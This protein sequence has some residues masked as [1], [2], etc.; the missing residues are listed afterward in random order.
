MPRT[1]SKTSGIDNFFS[2]TEEE[3]LDNAEKDKES[4]EKDKEGKDIEK[5]EEEKGKEAEKDK[6]EGEEEQEAKPSIL[7]ILATALGDE[8][9]EEFS[10]KENQTVDDLTEYVKNTRASHTTHFLNQVAEKYPDIY[11]LLE[12]ATKGGDYRKLY[13]QLTPIKEIADDDSAKKVLEEHYKAKGLSEKVIKTI[14]E[15]YEAEE[16]LI[17]EANKVNE[18]KL[19]EQEALAAKEVERVKQE[20]ERINKENVAFVE[21]LRNKI[22]SKKINGFELQSSETK[23]LLE[24]V[25]S[26]TQR[27]SDGSYTVTLPMNSEEDLNAALQAFIVYS[28]K[29]DLDS[30]LARKRTTLNLQQAMKNEKAKA[31]KKGGKEINSLDQFFKN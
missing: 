24:K 14:L 30:Y 22:Y 7:S 12:V 15:D 19:K 27:N 17:Q 13:E 29:G 6:E 21:K 31:D 8:L 26:R 11:N 4:E 9:P 10:T 20:E 25:V 23:E 16:S 2:D 28:K 1:E 3:V 18:E 5:D